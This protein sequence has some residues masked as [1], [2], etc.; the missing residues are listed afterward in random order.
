MPSK[1]I[2]ARPTPHRCL[3]A[4]VCEP[5]YPWCLD[6]TECFAV[7]GIRA[8]PRIDHSFMAEVSRLEL[9]ALGC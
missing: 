7:V 9:I 3:P 4:R 1:E 2:P 8:A 5:P 6:L